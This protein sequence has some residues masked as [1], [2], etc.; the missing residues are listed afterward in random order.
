MKKARTYIILAL[1]AALIVYAL[2]YIG[3]QNNIKEPFAK[4]RS[5]SEKLLKESKI[6]NAK[7]ARQTPV[8]WS[9]NNKNIRDMLK[10]PIKHVKDTPVKRKTTKF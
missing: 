5:Y 7:S 8:T 1:I 4:Y 6:L 9:G 3:S 10:D 2:L